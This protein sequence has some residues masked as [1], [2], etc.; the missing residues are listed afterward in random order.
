MIQEKDKLLELAQLE[1]A[2]GV[3]GALLCNVILL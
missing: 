2:L 1:V 3:V